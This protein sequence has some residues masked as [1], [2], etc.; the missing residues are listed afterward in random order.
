MATS[1]IQVA[2]HAFQHHFADMEQQRETSTFGMWM[3]LLTEIMFFGGLFCAYLVYRASYYQAFVEGSQKMNIWLGATNTAVLICSS[4]TMALAVRCAQLG[5]RKLMGWLLIFTMIFGFAFLGI[6][7][8]EY[9]E[10]WENHEFPGPHFHFQT[11][12]PQHPA[13]DPVHT[14]IYFSLY[15]AMTGLHALHMIIGIGLVTWILLA[16]MAGA[17][18]PIYYSPV[19]NV[20]LYWHFVDL[21]WI[22][23]F[24]LLYLISKKHGGA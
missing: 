18:S 21:V 23:L 5:K 22:Y 3:F 13:T 2:E 19:E 9:T 8:K 10:H 6:K 7:A 12:D 14:E 4:L 17:Y 20:G 24:P 1:D 15:W 16:G 11:G